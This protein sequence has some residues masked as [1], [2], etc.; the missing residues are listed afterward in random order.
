MR[1]QAIV[2]VPLMTELTL[3]HY[4]TTLA[5]LARH[6]RAFSPTMCH[7]ARLGRLTPKRGSHSKQFEDVQLLLRACRL[8]MICVT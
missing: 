8:L 5:M 3:A 6:Q 1:F 7:R 2:A 4:R